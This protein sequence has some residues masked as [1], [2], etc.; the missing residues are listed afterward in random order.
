V[1]L[2]HFPGAFL[3]REQMGS[4]K[5]RAELARLTEE[6]LSNRLS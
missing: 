6:R 1:R 3:F 5:E 2:E 4:E